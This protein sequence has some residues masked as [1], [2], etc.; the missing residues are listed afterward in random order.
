MRVNPKLSTAKLLRAAWQ[1]I[2]KQRQLRPARA[3]LA[4]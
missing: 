3:E 1:V 2:E 4:A